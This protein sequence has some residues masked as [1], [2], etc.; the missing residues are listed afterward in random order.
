MLY[1]HTHTQAWLSAPAGI[2][3]RLLLESIKFAHF[4][5]V[6]QGAYISEQGDG[7][8][9][10]RGGEEWSVNNESYINQASFFL[11]LSPRFFFIKVIALHF[12]FLIGQE[13]HTT[14]ITYP[15]SI[16]PSFRETGEGGAATYIIRT[17]SCPSSRLS[18]KFRE[19]A[20]YFSMNAQG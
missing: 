15:F 1:P 18:F 3:V 5:R 2:P 11:P 6:F 13:K 12:I 17:E 8:C 14:S 10:W 4:Y 19:S 9:E 16:L 7:L 20:D